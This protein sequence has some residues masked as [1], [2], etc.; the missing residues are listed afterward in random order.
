MILLIYKM[1]IKYKRSKKLVLSVGAWAPEIYGHSISEILHVERRT[2]FWFDSVS[3]DS[4]ASLQVTITI[5]L[6]VTSICYANIVL[7]YLQSIPIYIWDYGL[8]NFYGFPSESGSPGGNKVAFHMQS[9]RSECTP[10]SIN[11]IVS[12]KEILSMREILK[13]FIPELN[14]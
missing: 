3:I 4:Q 10:A 13:S 2:L 5:A 6:Q 7:L 9:I 1:C 8:G 12:D 14:G 11:R